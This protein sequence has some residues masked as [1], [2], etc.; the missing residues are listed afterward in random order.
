MKNQLTLTATDMEA[1]SLGD[2]NYINNKGANLYNE[3]TY[4]YS[5][6]YYR[7]SAAMG[8]VHSIS[9]LGYCYL[10]G[11]DIKANTSLAIAYFKIAALKEDIDAAYKL[12]DIYSSNKWGVKDTELSVYY[13][14]MAAS[15]ILGS[16]WEKEY[17]LIWEE[18]L[19][20]YPSL[21]YALARELSPQG[22]MCTDINQ[23]YQFLVLA[24]Y[25]YESAIADGN[26]MYEESYQGVLK[27]MKKKIYNAVREKYDKEYSDCY[28]ETDNEE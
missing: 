17:D 16:R 13:Y 21:C 10:Y 1:I 6:D 14:R 4:S 11:R 22:N 7:L 2:S 24:K 12:G 19:K 15:Y 18:K 20:E 8:N 3:G 23:S 27:W 28:L 9:N 26:N 5:V 25:G